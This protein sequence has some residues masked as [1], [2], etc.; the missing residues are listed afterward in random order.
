MLLVL[1]FLVLNFMVPPCD[2]EAGYHAQSADPA[3]N[4]TYASTALQKRL[5]KKSENRCQ[6]PLG[7]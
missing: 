2:L 6:V 1:N 5:M 4:R 3:V 7:W